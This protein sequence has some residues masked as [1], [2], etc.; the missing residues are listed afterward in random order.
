MFVCLNSA[1]TYYRVQFLKIN[2]LVILNKFLIPI[3]AILNQ[4]LVDKEIWCSSNCIS[5]SVVR[6]QLWGMEAGQNTSFQ[7][8]HCNICDSTCKAVKVQ[9]PLLSEW[10]LKVNVTFY[11]QGK[12][13]IHF[14]ARKIVPQKESS[15]KFLEVFL[16]KLLLKF[17]KEI[18]NII[19]MITTII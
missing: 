18:Y 4:E 2:D 9:N 17:E 14:V 16:A 8:E 13:L 7:K 12:S 5:N 11:T 6:K 1:D 3:I 19:I 10:D 15:Q